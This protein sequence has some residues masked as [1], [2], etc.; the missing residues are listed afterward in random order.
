M[1]N[2]N[3]NQSILDIRS[4]YEGT[5]KAIILSL[6]LLKPVFFLLSLP[7]FTRSSSQVIADWIVETVLE[8]D[9][10]YGVVLYIRHFIRFI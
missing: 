5:E 3:Q 7:L 4:W 9:P 6:F 8:C 2:V 10:I 1:Q